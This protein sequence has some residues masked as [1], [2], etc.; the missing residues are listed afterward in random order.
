[1][2]QKQKRAYHRKES[3]VENTPII[4]EESIVENT[5]EQSQLEETINTFINTAQKAKVSIIIPMFGYW[6]DV[7]SPQL[8]EETLRISCERMISNIHNVYTI[9]VADENRLS[10]QVQNTLI[11]LSQ[12]GNF[13][14]VSAKITDTYGDYVRKGINCALATDSEYI[15]VINPWVMLQHNAI[16]ILVDLIN[17]DAAK[18]VSAYDMNKT[19]DDVAFISHK[20][21]LPKD[22]MG[23]D[24]NMF[25]MRRYTAEIINFD[26]N[27]KTHFFIGR[28]AWQTLL[29]KGFQCMITERVPMFSFNIN[30]K[31]LEGNIEYQEDKE[32]FAKKWHFNVDDIDYI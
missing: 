13:K 1:M 12:A 27:F 18:V 22:Y 14:G 31:E 10:K 29:Q 28:D 15:I 11:N 24:M 30:W 7:S 23:I 3:V 6:N 19:I 20:F 5:I 8:N 25:G 2:Q 26:D 17:H 16:D 32:Y 4:K 9:F 21:H